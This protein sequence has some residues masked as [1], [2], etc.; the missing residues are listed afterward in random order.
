VST[1]YED[2]DIDRMLRLLPAPGV[3]D[4]VRERHLALL[5]E[6][7]GADIEAASPA[8][9]AT[10]TLLRRPR[11]HRPYRSPSRRRR[12]VL[13]V[14]VATAI[15]VSGTAAATIAWV[16]ANDRTKIHCY[17]ILTQDFDNPALGGDAVSITSDTVAHAI[18]ICR[19]EWEQGYLT[20]TPPYIDNGTPVPTTA[21]PLIACVLPSGV[22][23][24]FPARNHET[25]QSLGLPS[26]EG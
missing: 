13:A 1:T 21:P 15:V 20:S 2:D 10:R 11:A 26:S 5:R 23:G 12:V 9:P 8:A 22:V 7:I 25:C 17:P 19:S 24:V 18:D 16:R 6:V 14:V 3:P 4:D